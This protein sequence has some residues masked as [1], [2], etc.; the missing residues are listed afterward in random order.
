MVCLYCKNGTNPVAMIFAREVSPTLTTLINKI[1]AATGDHH[2]DH[3]GSFVVFLKYNEVMARQVKQL[4][5]KECI[6]HTVL[7]LDAPAGAR[8][9]E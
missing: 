9:T 7:T 3:M 8:G 1:D 5:D 6:Q 2:S 4:A